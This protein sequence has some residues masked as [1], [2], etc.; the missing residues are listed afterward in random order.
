MFII[1]HLP[2]GGT[3]VKEMELAGDRLIT[4]SLARTWEALNDPEVLRRSIPGCDSL[5]RVGDNHFTAHLSLRIGPVSAKFTGEVRL[6]DVVPQRGYR[7]DF[8]GKGG[9]AGFGRGSANVNLTAEGSQTRLHYRANATVGGKI[10]QVGSRLVDATA[11][12]LADDFFK[13]FEA[14]VAEQPS[15]KVVAPATSAVEAPPGSVSESVLT[16]GF[17]VWPWLVVGAVAVLAT[18]YLF[19]H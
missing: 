13:R 12:K 16:R 15:E 19:V 17:P 11:A 14:I 6:K 8:D 9:V 1:N 10:A 5:E 3:E 2:E 4:A 7:I 18:W